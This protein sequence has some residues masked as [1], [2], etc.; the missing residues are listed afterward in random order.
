MNTQ[1]NL[2]YDELSLKY[3]HDQTV[4]NFLTCLSDSYSQICGYEFNRVEQLPS[5]LFDVFGSDFEDDS[6]LYMIGFLATAEEHLGKCI[7]VLEFYNMQHEVWKF[8]DDLAKFEGRLVSTPSEKRALWRKI[9]K[10]LKIKRNITRITKNQYVGVL[11]H[12]H[13]ERI[14]L[15]IKRKKSCYDNFPKF[16]K[17]G[18]V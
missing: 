6:H 1:L 3:Y 2:R 11:Y 14:L 5:W 12:I 15:D 9:K 8:A 13:S 7:T 17:E 10:D 18:L 16:K 4:E